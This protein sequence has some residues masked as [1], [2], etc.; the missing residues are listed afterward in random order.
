MAS[1]AGGRGLGLGE[2]VRVRGY[3]QL[4]WNSLLSC[5]VLPPPL[6]VG[7]DLAAS[8][9]SVG[10]DFSGGGGDGSSGGIG[11]DC[12]AC[13]E[14]IAGAC[15]NLCADCGGGI[16][17][18][19]FEV[20]SR[21]PPPRVFRGHVVEAAPVEVERRAVLVRLG[22]ATPDKTCVRH[23]KLFAFVCTSHG[24]AG[25]G[26]TGSARSGP[27]SGVRG[28]DDPGTGAVAALP[29]DPA[30]VELLCVDCVDEHSGHALVRLSDHATAARTR[31]TQVLRII[32][33]RSDTVAGKEAA[34]SDSVALVRARALQMGATLDAL[35]EQVAD[36]LEHAAAARDAVFAAASERF[37]T[38][39]S[40]IGAAAANATAAFAADVQ[41]CDAVVERADA[42]RANLQQAAAS[43]DD[44]DAVTYVGVLTTAVLAVDA[45][46]ARV[47]AAS[48]TTARVGLEVGSALDDVVRAVQRLGVVTTADDEVAPPAQAGAPATAPL[49][50]GAE[51]ALAVLQVRVRA[52]GVSLG[53]RVSSISTCVCVMMCHPNNMLSITLCVCFPP[54]LSAGPSGS[55]FASRTPALSCPRCECG[56][57]RSCLR[58]L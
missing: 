49:V 56:C 19:C 9:G 24:A 22:L 54:F 15:R 45:E 39:E 53:E 18:R 57:E 20:H 5:P 11:S 30:A 40:A 35:P 31:L 29:V 52:A 3:A 4:D 17:D 27:S 28:E 8:H 1:R 13:G 47:A 41:A 38:L 36:A 14:A 7:S 43:F 48:V 42:L 51:T 32:G 10:G 21:T 23:A 12:A 26:G 25:A 37:S 33:G 50:T 6:W 44:V 58:Y 46:A 55:V 34:Q 2:V 16:C